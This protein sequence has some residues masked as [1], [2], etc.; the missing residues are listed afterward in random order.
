MFFTYLI[1][2]ATCVL[3]YTGFVLFENYQ[4]TSMQRERDSEY[5]LNEISDIIDERILDAQNAVQNLR[6]SSAMKNLYMAIKLGST[7]DAYD[8][9][10]I[11]SEM[12]SAVTSR[13]FSI[14]GITIFADNSEKAYSSSGVIYLPNKYTRP[15]DRQLPFYAVGTVVDILGLEGQNW[16]AYNKINLIYCDNYT[17]QNGTSIGTICVMMD[18]SDIESEIKKVLGSDEGIAAFYNG[19][20]LFTVGDC[21]GSEIFTSVSRKNSEITFELHTSPNRI[22]VNWLAIMPIL[23]GIVVVSI[24]FIWLAYWESK[25]YYQPI[26]EINR[27]VS[28]APITE[29]EDELSSITRGIEQLIGEKNSYREQMLTISPYAGAGVMQAI[30]S[31]E[32]DQDKISILSVEDFLDLKRP[33][34]IVSVVNFAYEGSTEK[35]HTLSQTVENV[36]GQIVEMFTTEECRVSYYF[37]DIFN[38]YLIL[39]YDDEGDKDELFFSIH[40]TISALISDAHCAVSMGVDRQ[41]DDITELKDACENAMKALDGVLRD[42]RGE[43]FFHEENPEEVVS[44]YFPGD[45]RTK[46]Q[47]CLEKRD[48]ISVHELLFDIYKKNLD[49]DAP[50]EVYRALL[51]EVHLSIIKQLREMTQLRTV[52]LNVDKPLGLVTLQEAFDYYDAALISAIDYLDLQGDK[53]KADKMLDDEI[54][55]YVDEHY[56]DED[57]SLQTLSD[58]F[59]VS[60]KYLI[61]LFKQ[62]FNNTYLQYLQNKRIG[63]AIELLKEGK[64]SLSEIGVACG[65][66]NQLTFRRNFKSLV[67]CNPSDFQLD[68]AKNDPAR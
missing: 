19:E 36:L 58:R 40:R 15:E 55:T 56:C 44:Y 28:Q 46:L 54:I 4:I 64:M 21:S 5:T 24:F 12:H 9:Q 35:R 42:S 47:I 3:M 37:K 50:S 33:Y 65:Y 29:A 31:G 59:N 16:Y 13:G 66:S 39:N 49:L 25:K 20:E 1:V 23:I 41:R 32:P 8:S 10:L 30:V 45:F 34:Y 63:K 67:G 43:I 2:I 51:D 18:M 27:L 14:Y 53:V 6:F 61:L 48:R 57:I 62:K 68:L 60:N 7:L 11:A 26:D 22:L 17:Y 38:S 52:H